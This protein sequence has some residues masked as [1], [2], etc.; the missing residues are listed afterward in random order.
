[1]SDKAL[2]KPFLLYTGLLGP[3]TIAA[4][5]LATNSLLSLLVATA[6]GLLIAVLN[7]GAAGGSSL[8]GAE[9][10]DEGGMEVEATGMLPH[11]NGGVP[12][13]LTLLFYGLGLF[14]WGALV[15]FTLHDRLA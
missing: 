1:M 8:G 11:T 10:S 12:F 13:R 6:V 7:G 14:L 4:I 15:L 9:R 3:L 2:W 5:Y